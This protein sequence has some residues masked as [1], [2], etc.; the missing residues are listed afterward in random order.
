MIISGGENIAPVEVANCLREHAG[1]AD[2]SVYGLPDAK[3]GER[4]GAAIRVEQRADW[5]RV[6]EEELMAWC[7]SRL[8]PFKVPSAIRFVA[9]FQMTPSRQGADIPPPRGRCSSAL[10]VS[11]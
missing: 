8:A 9:Q 6:T 11:R 1:V 4:V 3:L 7:E 10:L 2:A 5:P